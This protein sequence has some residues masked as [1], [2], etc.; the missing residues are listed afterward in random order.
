MTGACLCGDVAFEAEA[1]FAFMAHC[2]CS[3]CRKAGGAAFSTTLG[4]ARDR[5]RWVRGVDAIRRYAS[6]SGYARP[7]CARCGSAV[8]HA[9]GD[10]VHVPAGGLD[11]DPVTRPQAHLFVGSKAPWH[12]IADALP[13]FEAYPPGLGEAVAFARRSEANPGAVRGSCL[14]GGVAYEIAGTVAGPIIDCHCSRCRKARGAAHAANVFV[15]D[16]TRF[17]WLRGEDLLGYYKVPE[18]E[19]FAQTFCRTCGAK[20]PGVNRARGR[21]AVPAGSLDDD[22]GAR[23]ELHIF[24]G[25]KAPWFEIVDDLPQYDGY[26][27]GPYPPGSR[28]A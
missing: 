17:R 28:R 14:C 18:A 19:R 11:G 2:H 8:P 15:E 7:F 6:S 3:M 10:Q 26:P 16:L 23:E 1:P 4:V 27:P 25:S 21:V 22:P 12:E 9:A 13:R 20:M 24:V 5:F